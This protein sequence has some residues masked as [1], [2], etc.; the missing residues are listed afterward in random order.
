MRITWAP[1]EAATNLD[2]NF[3]MKGTGKAQVAVEHAKL[4]TAAEAARMKRFWRGKLDKMKEILQ[5]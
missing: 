4:K 3:L 5:A 2:V 1:R